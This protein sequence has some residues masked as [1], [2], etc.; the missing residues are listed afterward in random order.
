MLDDSDEDDIELERGFYDGYGEF[1]VSLDDKE[2]KVISGNVVVLNSDLEYSRN[3]F[4]LEDVYYNFSGVR[5]IEVGKK[6]VRDDDSDGFSDDDDDDEKFNL[7]LNFY[8]K[9]RCIVVDDD[10]D[11]EWRYIE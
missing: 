10:D 7:L 2:N 6:R 5:Y 3:I 1:N 8:K 9:V 4:D 11:E